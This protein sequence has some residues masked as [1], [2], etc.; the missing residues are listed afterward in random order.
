MTKGTLIIHVGLP[1]TATTFLKK[2]IFSAIKNAN[3]MSKLDFGT[4]LYDD[5]V[6]IVSAEHMSGEM[7]TQGNSD[8]RFIIADRLKLCFPDA[9]IIVG[10]RGSTSWLH[11][12]YSQYVKEG[13]VYCYNDWYLKLFDE[14]YL[15]YGVYINY[16]KKLFK[17]VHIY[18]F[19]ELKKDVCRSVKDMCDFIGVSVPCFENKKYNV[20]LSDRQLG[21]LRLL[22][23]MFRSRQNPDGYLPRHKKWNVRY[24]VM[25][26]AK[27]RMIK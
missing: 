15:N 8:K 4:K 19:E 2:N 20:S 6:N 18:Q 23:R 3:Y 22:N 14:Q 11:S 17:D 21:V 16:L 12:L 5:K 1:K 7:F 24:L 13:G 27:Y 25:T 9:K 26:L 10:I